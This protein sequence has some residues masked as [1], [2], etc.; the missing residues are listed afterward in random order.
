LDGQRQVIFI[1]GEAGIGKTTLIDTFQDHAASR[2]NLRIVRGQCVEG[3]GGKEPYYPVLEALGQL[4]RDAPDSPLVSILIK[5]KR[6]PT[7][8]IQFSSL[9]KAEQRQ[10]PQKE[11]LG[12]TR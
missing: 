9:V 6:A 4:I 3:F 10:A 7:W 8:L 2:P 11:T 12:T 5:I 1:T